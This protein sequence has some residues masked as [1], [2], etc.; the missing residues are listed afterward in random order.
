MRRVLNNIDDMRLVYN[1]VTYPQF[2]S[3]ELVKNEIFNL[4]VYIEYLQTTKGISTEQ[5]KTN[6]V[7]AHKLK[8]VVEGL[9]KV[10][11]IL[12]T[13][14]SNSILAFVSPEYAEE[15]RQ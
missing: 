7:L 14:S 10:V 11:D 13:S 6:E 3:K 5:K 2:M 12:D 9:E 1:K 4:G 15:L 8:E